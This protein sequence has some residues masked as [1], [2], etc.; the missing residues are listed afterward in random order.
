MLRR[1]LCRLE[2]DANGKLK[3]LARRWAGGWREPIAD[4]RF[5]AEC[6]LLGVNPAQMRRKPREDSIIDIWPDMADSVAIFLSMATQWNWSG[7]LYTLGRT[8]LIY[9]AIE[10]TARGL[11]LEVTPQVFA[12]IQTMESEALATWN[13]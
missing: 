8:R 13:R 1:S 11:G 12:D 7:S 9:E 2:R 3:R 6:R 4:D 10:P 5:D